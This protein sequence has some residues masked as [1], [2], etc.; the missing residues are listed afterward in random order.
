MSTIEE[1][2]DQGAVV[3]RGSKVSLFGIKKL[4]RI[5]MNESVVP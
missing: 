4:A 2:G 3:I 5:L 1:P